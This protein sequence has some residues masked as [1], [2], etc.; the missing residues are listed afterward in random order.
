MKLELK[1][2]KALTAE[3]QARA[4]EIGKP[5]T[6][7]VVDSAGF[8]VLAE[9]M[10]NGRPLTTMISLSKAYTAAIM[11]RPSHMLKAWCKSQPEYF[12]QVS[13]MGHQPIVATE[14]GMTLKKGGTI[15][16]G[17]GV[18]GGTGEEDGEIALAA[19]QACGYDLDFDEWSKIRG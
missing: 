15:L 5:V 7:T 2:A 14:G 8:T 19:L 9:R 11:E 13:R 3:A 4:K 6:V 10:D 17:L 1:D 18:A 16:G 12:Y